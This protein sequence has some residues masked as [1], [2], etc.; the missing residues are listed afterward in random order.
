MT[1]VEKESRTM[2][3]IKKD[4]CFILKKDMC[5][6]WFGVLAQVAEESKYDG[7]KVQ[8]Q[9]WPI[10]FLMF[11]NVNN[12]FWGSDDGK[13]FRII[14]GVKIDGKIFNPRDFDGILNAL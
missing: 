7:Y 4:K 10:N 6:E 3:D 12:M 13:K 9:E 2:S 14:F 1:K 11:D 5:D 8:F